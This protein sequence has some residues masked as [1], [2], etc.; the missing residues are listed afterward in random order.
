MSFKS[1]MIYLLLTVVAVLTVVLAREGGEA[2][3]TSAEPVKAQ[4]YVQISDDIR[5][6]DDHERGVSCYRSTGGYLS[7]VKVNQ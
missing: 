3:R 6:T 5:R 4:S 2:I 7:C 1:A